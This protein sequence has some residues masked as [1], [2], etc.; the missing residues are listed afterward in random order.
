MFQC[1]EKFPIIVIHVQ[2]STSSEAKNCPTTYF[3]VYILLSLCTV[4]DTQPSKEKLK[5]SLYPIFPTT[6]LKKKITHE[7]LVL[8]ETSI[9]K[10]NEKFY[11]SSM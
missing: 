8:I 9:A 1:C 7:K 4:N 2:D 3:H 10:F 6:S 11:I 5:F